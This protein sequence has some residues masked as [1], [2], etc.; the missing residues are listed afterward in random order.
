MGFP[1]AGTCLA[2]GA[3]GPIPSYKTRGDKS[4]FVMYGSLPAGDT[5]N[6]AVFECRACGS[7]NL[8]RVRIV[9]TSYFDI[10]VR[11][12][13]PQHFAMLEAQRHAGA[14]K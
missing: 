2:C 13:E 12:G 3:S 4:A 9:F 7:F 11:P 1:K 8:M 14:R 5:L 6:H 10:V